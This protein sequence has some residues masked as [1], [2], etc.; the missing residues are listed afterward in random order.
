MTPALTDLTQ[1]DWAD[2]SP[3]QQARADEIREQMIA[4]VATAIQA[5]QTPLPNAAPD[6]VDEL[7]ARDAAIVD[8]LPRACQ[9][10]L[11]HFRSPRWWIDVKRGSIDAVLSRVSR[12]VDGASLSAMQRRTHREINGA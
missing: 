6:R 5:H 9:A 8:A 1:P 11:D 7:A 4:D 2:G 3:K 12:S 10:V